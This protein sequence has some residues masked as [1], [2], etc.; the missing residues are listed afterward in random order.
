[1]PTTFLRFI[2]FSVALGFHN[3]Q[4]AP[5]TCTNVE[6]VQEREGRPKIGLVLG[7]GG[8][9]GGA[10][11][12]VLKALEQMRVP[13]DY[14]AGTSVGALIGG[15]YASGMSPA[16]IELA[17]AEIDWSDILS[18]RPAR[19]DLSFRRREDNREYLIVGEYGVDRDG[20]KLPRGLIQGQKVLAL[21]QRL[22][23]PG[24]SYES[25][26]C[27]PVPFRAVATDLSTG[28]AVELT[29]GDLAT[30]MRASMSIPGVFTPVDHDGRILID[31][32]IVAN[33]P[34]HVVRRM[35]AERII[36]VD[37]GLPLRQVRELGD[38]FA[39]LSQSIALVL[40]REV[41]RQIKGLALTDVVIQ[42]ELGDLG[43]Q[44]L[45]LASSAVVAGER[46][47]LEAGDM[48]SAMA[49]SPSDYQRWYL[50]RQPL[51]RQWTVDTI[52]IDHDSRL[53]DRVLAARVSTDP[54]DVLTWH[55]VDADVKRIYEV[56]VFESVTAE[57]SRVEDTGVLS[58]QAKRKEWGPDYLNFGLSLQDDFQGNAQYDLLLR[59]TKMEL[60]ALG[61]ELRADARIGA[62]PRL[63][64]EWYQPL[65]VQSRYFL[66]PS[67]EWG[68]FNVD[69]VEDGERI[70]R[71]RV[72]E[73]LAGI[74]VGRIF[75]K[76]MEVRVG[77]S[78]ARIKA[79]PR[80]GGSIPRSIRE[81][82][83]RAYV[84]AF[85]YDSLDN[86]AFPRR[87]SFLSLTGRF[88][89][90]GLGADFSQDR[91]EL[92]WFHARTFGAS[93]L[94][95]GTNLG[96]TNRDDDIVQSFFRLGG[97]LNLSGFESNE[98]IGPHYG[99]ASLLYYRRLGLSEPAFSVPTYFGA[100]LESGNVWGDRNAAS[101]RNTIQ[102]GSVFF[103]ADTPLGPLY[104]GVGFAE[105][106]R[107]SA[108]LRL[109]SLVEGQ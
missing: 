88:T 3:A 89:D 29:R 4:A 36:A 61:G 91:W 47:T 9:R 80:I 65:D 103:G 17:I 40:Q 23:G 78:G 84:G 93:T 6:P 53:S 49:L 106:G 14:I 35:G 41:Q 99:L 94:A 82:D 76:A 50:S 72:T 57:Y 104:F 22:V 33:L 67:L 52:R 10:H 13:V 8:A 54:G 69:V 20:L 7:G 31:G 105:G 100:S 24:T 5:G 108:F 16:E 102:A 85:T 87:G 55:Q 96:T 34:I 83:D 77:L 44:D 92:N 11:I 12:G 59:L 62:H 51:H 27:L 81:L 97:P 45:H 86:V 63:F 60:N 38:P 64:A 74:D 39:V 79:D 32:A 21:L 95:F 66:A 46:A 2:V 30:A 15:M 101:M 37:V 42:P 18:D 68:E 98:L 43:T 70:R 75:G 19:S 26:D 71:L 73:Q 48:L 28:E 1:M 58:F 109:G 90:T 107:R 25:F 56:G